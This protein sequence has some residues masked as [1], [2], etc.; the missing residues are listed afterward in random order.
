M[1]NLRTAVHTRRIINP[2]WG[3]KLTGTA[4]K[5]TFGLLNASDQSPDDGGGKNKLFTIARMTYALGK[6]N[7][8]GAILTDTEHAGRRNRVQGGDL[9]IKLSPSQQLSA[10]FL[11]SQTGSRHATGSQV[12]YGYN[13]RRYTWANQIEHYGRDFRMDTAF[14]NRT[15]FTSGW[16]YGEM[17][18]YP[19][20]GSK[21]WLKKLSPFYWTKRGHDQVQDGKEDFVNTG[22]RFNTTRQGFFNFATQRGHE[23][24]IGRRFR[25]GAPINF[26]GTVQIVR[27]LN[28]NGSYGRNYDI[29]YDRVNPFQGRSRN[30]S[31]GIS[32]QPNPHFNQD[33]QINT[34]RFT[35]ASTGEKVFDV[36]IVNTRTTY[37]FN[38]H[39]LVRLLEQFDSSTHRLLTDLLAS[40]EFV[41]GTVFHAGYGSLYR[42]P[43][44]GNRYMT[45][46]RGLFFK[47][48]YL[49]RF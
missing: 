11:A 43:E 46:N 45:V 14:Y 30:R 4:G 15:G 26:F 49:H 8:V 39:F 40:Y 24:W 6:S 36:D 35:R 28:V 41:P 19:K 38:R 37:Q 20:E 5:V 13:S 42:K 12:G 48:S 9:S 27:W 31:I 1:A 16:S 32:F 7:Y 33:I 21:F 44:D 2:F 25:T 18:F 17:N 23:P 3:S 34:V 29:F 22:I 10:T 47:A